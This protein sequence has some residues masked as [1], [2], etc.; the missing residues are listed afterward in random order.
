MKKNILIGSLLLLSACTTS[1]QFVKTG[2]KSFS[3]FSNGCNVTVYTTNPKKEFEEIGLIEFGKSF[4]EGRP[5][6]L[7]RAKEEAAPF[8]CKNGGNGMLVWEAN[9]YGQYLKATII[10][11]K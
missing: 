11:T 9:G 7:T 6:N 1:T 8:V 4:V 5:S 10:R 2:D 3:P